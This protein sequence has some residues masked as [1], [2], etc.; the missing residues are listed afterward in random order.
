MFQK[1]LSPIFQVVCL[2]IFDFFGD[3]VPADS[4][5]SEQLGLRKLY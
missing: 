5:H 1:I 2:S 3:T 4:T